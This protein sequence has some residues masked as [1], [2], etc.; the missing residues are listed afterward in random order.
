MSRRRPRLTRCPTPRNARPPLSTASAS[1]PVSAP[2]RCGASSPS[3]SRCWHPPTPVEIVAHRVV[4][5]LLFCCGPA[6][7]DAR[8]GRVLAGAADTPHPRA[9]RDRG[10]AAADQLGH[11]RLRHPDRPG[12]RRVARLLHQPAGHRDPGRRACCASGCGSLQWVAR[13]ASARSPSS[14]SPSA[15]GKLPWIALV[16]AA[17]LR[18]L[19]VDQEPR[20]PHGRGDPRARRRDAGAR[21]ARARLPALA[22]QARATGRSP[23]TASATR[24]SSRPRAS[25]PPC[26]CCCSA[27]PRVACR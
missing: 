14:S 12:G 11:V 2:T 18:L 20:R 27:R 17:A 13:R 3:T 21:A 4:W 6:V 1:P 10:R 5:S 19:R 22:R 9:A 23:R 15:T 8:L 24:S 25:S 7:R 16:L 26:R